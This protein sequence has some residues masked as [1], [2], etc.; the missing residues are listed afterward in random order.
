MSTI[1]INRQAELRLLV[2]TFLSERL[3]SKL[4]KLDPDDPKRDEL[5]KQFIPATWLEDAARRA[6]Q[7]QAVTHSLK[8]VHPDAKGTNLYSPPGTLA[9]IELV[10]SHCLGEAFAGDVVGNAAALDVYKFLKQMHEGRSLLALSVEG[11]ADL[12]AALSD[13]PA[14]AQAWLQAFATLTEPRGRVTSHTLAK[15]LYWQT[16]DDVQANESYHL[17]SP[18]YASSL[19]HRVYETLQ[20]DRFS[21]AAKAARDARKVN[22]FSERPVHEYPQMAVQ[23]LGGTKPQNISQ[24]N[25]ERRGNNCLL[26]SLPPVWRSTDL[27][28]LLNTDSMFHRYSRRP[29]VRQAVKALL[30]FLKTDPTRNV[31]TRSKRAAWV[32][33]LI[34]EFL[35]FTAELRSLEPGWS[36]T[37][38][39]KLTESECRWLDDDGVKATDAELDR[40]PP[41]DIPERIS[42][43][44]ANWLNAQLRP[45]LPM[46]DPEFLEW[47]NTMMEE[48]KAQEREGMYVE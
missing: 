48:I 25:S 11:D 18:L 30:A 7:I 4:E 26:A 34:D 31:A 36:Q 28:P 47:R 27:K 33:L 45:P 9:A 13:D 14:Q 6:A 37:P 12:A 17:L 29:E 41:T 40:A 32:N 23:Q 44:F 3:E 38:Q 1:S 24:L 2:S 35:Q 43:A 15:Q 19:A 20:D 21:E 46:G 8:P 16:G 22:T 10:G 5:R 39:C 42:A